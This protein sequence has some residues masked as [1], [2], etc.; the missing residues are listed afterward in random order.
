[1]LVGIESLS[2]GSGDDDLVGDGFANSIGGGNGNDTL[3][4]DGGNDVLNG[5]NGIDTAD[6][7]YAAAALGISLSGGN[8]TVT[9][10]AGDVDQLWSIENL[11]GGSGDDT[12]IGDAARNFLS[13]AGGNDTLRGG[14]DNDTLRGGAGDD[15]LDGQAG[16]N[17]ALYDYASAAITT[18]ID[19]TGTVT[20]V[21]AA[22]DTDTLVDIT[23]LVA[24]SGD[25]A[26]SGDAA[27]NTILGG[28]GAHAGRVRGKRQSLRR[29]RQRSHRWRSWQRPRRLRLR[30][31]RPDRHVALLRHADRDRRSGRHGRDHRH[32][33]VPGRQRR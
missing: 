26:I 10:A 16:I 30:R 4:G 21:V 19:S 31:H 11:L 7:R 28:A 14:A 32:G 1:M 29:R 6:Y 13:G 2:G 3:R 5:G 18:T 17:M 12:L 27:A 25:D 23:H 24:G 8:A 9:V 15:L 22:G 33:G 20:L